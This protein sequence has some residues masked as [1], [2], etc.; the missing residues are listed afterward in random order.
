MLLLYI[1]LMTVQKAL[2]DQ[3]CLNK[4]ESLDI[5]FYYCILSFFVV[6]LSL[7]SSHSCKFVIYVFLW[8]LGT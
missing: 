8:L 6:V 2:Q 1:I 4:C 5:G 3:F 7:I